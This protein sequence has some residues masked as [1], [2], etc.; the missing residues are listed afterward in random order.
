M[1]TKKYNRY[2]R[3]DSNGVKHIKRFELNSVVPVTPEPGYGPWIHGT[4][5]F[6]PQALLNVTRGL[7]R[8][9]TGVPKTP[10]QKELMRLAKLGVPKTQEHKDNM[11]KSWYARRDRKLLEKNQQMNGKTQ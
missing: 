11:R 6:A 7:Q 4:G 9:C 1:K 10:Q 2:H 5:P 3:Y 8:A